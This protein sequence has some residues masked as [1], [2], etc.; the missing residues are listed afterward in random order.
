MLAEDYNDVV[1][2]MHDARKTGDDID[3]V[4]CRALDLDEWSVLI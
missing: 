2:A 1:M 4:V 3:V